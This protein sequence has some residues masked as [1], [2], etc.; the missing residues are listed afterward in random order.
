[1]ATE[2][3]DTSIYQFGP[4]QLDPAERLLAR[5]GRPVALTPKA[6]D[7]LVYLVERHGGWP[8]SSRCSRPSGPTRSSRKPTAM[9]EVI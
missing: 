7:L 5:D 6:F 4:F 9:V 8:R 3:G 1:M 2:A